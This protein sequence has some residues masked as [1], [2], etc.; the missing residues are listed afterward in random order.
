MRD[1]LVREPGES[2]KVFVQCNDC[3]E[4]V[5]RYVIE[6]G[7]YYHHHKGYESY[8]RGLSRRGQF[9]SGKRVQTEYQEL[10]ETIT[11]RF[12]RVKELLHKEHKED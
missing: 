3:K 9:M 7:G 10:Q 8:L 4:L 2:D 11:E 6:P 1:I 12:E 5:A